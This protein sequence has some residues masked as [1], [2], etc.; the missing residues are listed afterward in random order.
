MAESYKPNDNAMFTYIDQIGDEFMLEH[1]LKVVYELQ[2]AYTGHYL[3]V[4]IRG[5]TNTIQLNNLESS[6]YVKELNIAAYK[7]GFS[8][9]F[10]SAEKERRMCTF[11]FQPKIEAVDNRRVTRFAPAELANIA[12]LDKHTYTVSL[13]PE[14]PDENQMVVNGLRHHYVQRVTEYNIKYRYVLCVYCTG[15]QFKST[16]QYLN[17]IVQT[18]DD[19]YVTVCVQDVN[20]LA[21]LTQKGAVNKELNILDDQHGVCSKVFYWYAEEY[22]QYYDQVA[23]KYRAMLDRYEQLKTIRS[24]IESEDERQNF[25]EEYNVIE[26]RDPKLSK[27]VDLVVML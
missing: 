6:H 7:S 1:R 11:Y 2:Q 5:I 20:D 14:T 17:D 4:C 12:Q 21:Q 23:Q 3:V 15:Q 22:S 27:Q 24:D 26:P 8:K 19:V 16:H 9:M 25:T 18:R 10:T 13:L